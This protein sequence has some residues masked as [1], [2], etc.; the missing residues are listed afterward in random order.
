MSS[1]QGD[2]SRPHSE[3]EST[4]SEADQSGNSRLVTFVAERLRE[5]DDGVEADARRGR[6]WRDARRRRYLVVADSIALAVA[7][8]LTGGIERGLWEIAFLPL[9]ILI[10]KIIGLYDRDHREVRHITL[11]EAPAIFVWAAL[12]V[13]ALGLCGQIFGPAGVGYAGMI[14]EAAITFSLAF[15]FRSMFR[16]LWRLRTPSEQVLI[17]GRGDLASTFRRKVELFDDLHMAERTEDSGRIDRVVIA[18]ER[19]DAKEISR[20]S[21]ICRLHEAKLS[22]VSPLRGQATPQEISRLAEMSIF[23]YGTADVSRSTLLLKRVLDLVIGIPLA[24]ASLIVA[25]PVAIAIRLEGSG[26]ILFRQ[27]RVGLDRRTFTLWKF[28]TMRVGAAEELTDL[29]AIEELEDPMFKLR[30]DPRVTKVGRLLRRFSLDEIPQMWNLIKGEMSL[31]GPRPEE[32]AIVSRYSPEHMFRLSVKP[33]LT[34]PMQVYGRGELTFQERLAVE[35]DYVERLS[36]GRDLRIIALTPLT[37][38]R[39]KGAF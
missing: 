37:V 2:T 16:G 27:V 38:A 24:L 19:L 39:G 23:E 34:G 1:R 15:V 18:S 36:I 20:I 26:P 8:L 13:V 30:S 33:G 7:V 6:W 5:G 12:S 10:A 35:L 11:D 14:E 28:R 32:V 9:A 21:Q 29:V 3:P 31:V 4:V 25:V 17:V 22:V